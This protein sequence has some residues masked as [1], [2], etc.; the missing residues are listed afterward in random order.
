M[1]NRANR[2]YDP[3]RPVDDCPGPR[4]E[5]CAIDHAAG[6][7]HLLEPHACT[8]IP[9][10]LAIIGSLTRPLLTHCLLGYLPVVETNV[11]KCIPHPLNGQEHTP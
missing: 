7:M 10:Q 11:P 5:D 9:N 3:H 1:Q 8:T 4:K 6:C 2:L